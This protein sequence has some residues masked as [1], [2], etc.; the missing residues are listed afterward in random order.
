[1]K[2]Q[3]FQAH[4]M[5]NIFLQQESFMGDYGNDTDDRH[6][7]KVR[8]IWNDWEVYRQNEGLIFHFDYTKRDKSIVEMTN[9][10][11]EKYCRENKLFEFN[12]KL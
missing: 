4:D 3:E 2:F 10:Q 11:F 1:M 5:K 7:D 8:K 6:D 12:T 9:E